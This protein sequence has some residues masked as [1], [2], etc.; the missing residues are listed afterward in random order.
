MEVFESCPLADCVVSGAEISDYKRMAWL[1]IEY[2][3][4]SKQ[5]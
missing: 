3:T 1:A 2:L 5:K 4:F